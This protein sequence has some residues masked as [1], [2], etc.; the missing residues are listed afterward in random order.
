VFE[1]GFAGKG[2][3]YYTHGRA[4]R[5]RLLCVGAKNTQKPDLEYL[6][7]VVVRD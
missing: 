2:R 5:F 1:M 6:S 3:L 4:L 7:K